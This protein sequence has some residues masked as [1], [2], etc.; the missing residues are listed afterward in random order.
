MAVVKVDL[1]VLEQVVVMAGMWE[2]ELVGNLVTAMA[3]RLVQ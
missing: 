1:L 3:E 2:H